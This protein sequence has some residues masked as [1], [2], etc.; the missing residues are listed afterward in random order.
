MS[1]DEKKI[2]VMNRIFKKANKKYVCPGCLTSFTRFDPLSDH[3]E[4][5]IGGNHDGLKEKEQS[6]FY[7][8]YR[9]LIGW[10]DEDKKLVLPLDRADAFKIDFFSQ[11]R[12]G[13]RIQC[14]VK[15]A[16][17]SGMKYVCPQCLGE[18]FEYFNT[19][20]DL[21]DHCWKKVDA[22]HMGLISTEEGNFFP[23]YLKAMNRGKGEGLK[24]PLA[25]RPRRGPRSYHD[26]LKIDYV[27]EE[28]VFDE[29]E[30]PREAGPGP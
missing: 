9:K 30:N 7:C 26:Y 15:I 8:S 18:D 1:E 3:L 22:T 11:H 10:Q 21:R 5:D 27:F 14:L 17:E 29:F 25:G 23:S 13:S 2:A 6:T 4:R 16:M 19:V 28:R 12:S 24:D 20:A